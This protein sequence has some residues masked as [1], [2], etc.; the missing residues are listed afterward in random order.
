MHPMRDGRNA[1]ACFVI[2]EDGTFTRP[3]D[4][5]CDSEAMH[6]ALGAEGLAVKDAKSLTVHPASD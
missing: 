6:N 3:N 4:G 1:G 5:I 2:K